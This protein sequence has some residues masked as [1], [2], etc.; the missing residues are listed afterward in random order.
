[1]VLTAAG[2][3][4][5][6]PLFD[7]P[8]PFELTGDSRSVAVGDLDGDGILDLAVANR[9]STL[10]VFRGAGDGT[11]GPRAQV[12][13][14]Q[15]TLAVAI[16]DLNGDGRLDLVAA[17]NDNTTGAVA[18]CPGHGDGTFG[19]HA[20]LVSG[21][22]FSFV[23]CA[24]V[25][26]DGWP[27][28]VAAA[29]IGPPGFP[30][31]LWLLPSRGGG[32]FG[33]AAQIASGWPTFVAIGDLNRDGHDD[34]AVCDFGDMS[35]GWV[36]VLLGL[37][38]GMF[39][40]SV[41]VRPEGPA[42]SVAIGDLN[43]DGWPDLV[44]GP[45][46]HW[47]SG[48]HRISVCLNDGEGGFAA[49]APLELGQWVYASSVA[50]ADLD[51]DGRLDIVV[52]D[53]TTP[54]LG[55]L[56]KGDGT[57]WG[58][59][60]FGPGGTSQV[61]AADVDRDALP[62]LVSVGPWSGLVFRNRCD[63][64]AAAGLFQPA[65][66]HGCSPGIGAM[67]AALAD[68]NRDGKNDVAMAYAVNNMGPTHPG[69]VVVILGNGAGGFDSCT[70]FDVGWQPRSV[71][72]ADLNRD[73]K[74]DVALVN[75]QSNTVSVLLA[76]GD[77]TLAPH[78]QY[79]AGAAPNGLA[80]ADLDRD[81]DA[82]LAVANSGANTV[83]VLRGLGD[84]T[85]AAREEH[86]VGGQ[87]A[88]IA[89][90]DF[91][92]DGDVD[93]A[94]A[95]SGTPS[96]SILLGDGLGGLTPGPVVELEDDP[97]HLAA[98]DLDRDGRF[99]LAVVR[100]G[101]QRVS[102]LRGRGDGGFDALAELPA[103]AGACW[104]VT[105]DVDVDGRPD[106]LVTN[107]DAGSLSSFLGNGDGTFAPRVDFDVGWET[108]ASSV[109]IGDLDRN[110]TPDVSVTIGGIHWNH[111]LAFLNGSH[112]VPVTVQD[113]EA[114]R[115]ERGL[116]LTWRLSE[117][118]RRA[119]VGVG[120]QRGAAAQG[121]WDERTT[122]WLEPAAEMSF[123]DHDVQPDAES[124]YRLALYGAEGLLA[125]AGPLHAQTESR[126]LRVALHAPEV[127]PGGGPIRVGYAVAGRPTPVQLTVHDV[128]GRLVWSWGPALRGPGEHVE[129]WDR[130]GRS[131]DVVPRGI[132]VVRLEAGEQ[133]AARKLALLRR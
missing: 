39:E 19:P 128:R 47:H 14:G 43:R 40:A 89:S 56:G 113:F 97:E 24:D 3:V 17:T 77:G 129:V 100:R 34:L 36:D 30:G 42:I 121:P 2:T 10:S 53:W 88:A 85:F 1:M 22:Q 75:R 6:G 55:F 15:P 76:H 67:S 92:R 69:G 46:E 70:W 71:C 63:K 58:V 110:G 74:P 9:D 91:D 106:L 125:T 68:L 37:G 49:T 99:D 82:D 60:T 83:S 26:E 4:A 13:A 94:V 23:A 44:L 35:S 57:F 116:R 52:G 93:L 130:R 111:F 18:M 90:G 12:A 51:V 38:D 108:W 54:C 66:R 45:G 72:S 5:A 118:A 33:P 86:A 64:T 20:L 16:A 127:T 114:Q 124:W 131:G 7:P 59:A 11:F 119:L 79:D 95:L 105:G 115:T 104:I 29:A 65:G 132:Y 120:V 78:V 31:S 109:A 41:R 117:D 8:I 112:P 98:A 28:V 62:D 101:A 133:R 122:R 96:V 103:A 107:W 27:D 50:V 32:T 123:E 21:P 126:S 25:N 81:G 73:D 61:V 84:G 48:T 102:I 87:P 80:V